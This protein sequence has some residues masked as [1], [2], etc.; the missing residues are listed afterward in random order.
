MKLITAVIRPETL[1]E[2]VRVL[3]GNG[4]RGLTATEV[5]GFGQQHGH[6]ATHQA[7]EVHGAEPAAQG[8]PGHR[9]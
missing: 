8:P 2:V 9:G 6:L 5:I 1:D 7:P 3:T 4:A